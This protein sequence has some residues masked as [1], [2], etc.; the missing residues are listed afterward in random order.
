MLVVKNLPANVGD[1]RNVGLIPGLGESPGGGTGNP[2]WYSCLENPMDRFG[3]L[4]ITVSLLLVISYKEHPYAYILFLPFP[5]F[6]R[7]SSNI[8]KHYKKVYS[9]YI[10]I[11]SHII[12]SVL[13][14]WIIIQ[15][16]MIIIPIYFQAN[17]VWVPNSMHLLQQWESVRHSVFASEW[18]YWIHTVP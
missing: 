10:L 17:E 7:L 1:I 2:F 13:N 11:H 14:E 16:C 5:Y 15:S 9:F 4:R 6:L 18:I 8:F 12:K 3:G